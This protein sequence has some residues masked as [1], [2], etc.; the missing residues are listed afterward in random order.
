MAKTWPWPWLQ[1]VW[2]TVHNLF[3]QRENKTKNFR[4][5]FF[6]TNRFFRPKKNNFFSPT[7]KNF[8]PKFCFEQKKSLT[9]KISN[10]KFCY[11]QQNFP[12]NFFFQSKKICDQ[13]YFLTNIFFQPPKNFRPTNLLTKKKIPTETVWVKP[14]KIL[15][16]SDSFETIKLF[17]LTRL[18]KKS[19]YKKSAKIN[20]NWLCH[21]IKLT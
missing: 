7:N 21:H 18:S 9:K 16:R 11:E 15:F 20:L 6:L 14:K 3:F 8:R 10:R 19:F 13:I 12:T 17:N 4:P 5:H 2:K 1:P